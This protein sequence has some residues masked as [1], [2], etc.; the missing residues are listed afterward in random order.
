MAA[1][2][3]Q[4]CNQGRIPCTR[5]A[6]RNAPPPRIF[7]WLEIAGQWI[8]DCFYLLRR[9]YRIARCRNGRVMSAWMALVSTFS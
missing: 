5:E 6:C 2:T 8:E 7:F 4:Q 9:C 1:C 3:S